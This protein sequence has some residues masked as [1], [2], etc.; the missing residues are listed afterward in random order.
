MQDGKLVVDNVRAN[1]MANVWVNVVDNVRANV[2]ANTEEDV[3]NQ[4]RM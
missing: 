4:S 1:V 2:W 3:R